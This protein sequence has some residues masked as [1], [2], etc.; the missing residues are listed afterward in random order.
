MFTSF[1]VLYCLYASLYLNVN[2][3]IHKRKLALFGSFLTDWNSIV[4]KHLG[5]L[6]PL[7]FSASCLIYSVLLQDGEPEVNQINCTVYILHG[8]SVSSNLF[9]R[10]SVRITL[11]CNSPTT[12]EIPVCF[13]LHSGVVC[14]YIFCLMPFL[15]L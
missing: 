5:H 3:K 10:G 2:E 14:I 8:S 4:T 11:Y 9:Y 1:T 6:K 12:E 13:V 7:F 15:F